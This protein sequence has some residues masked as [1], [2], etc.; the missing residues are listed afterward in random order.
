MPTTPADSPQ[1][2]HP[3]TGQFTSEPVFDD[4]AEA[5]WE[6]IARETVEFHRRRGRW[7]SQR[8]MDREGFLGGWLNG[9]RSAART[10]RMSDT[11]HAYLDELD[12]AWLPN[13]SGH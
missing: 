5:Y 8:A 13:R 9:Q 7:P 10:G 4:N 11:R 2:R 1:H 3:I 12:P 6:G